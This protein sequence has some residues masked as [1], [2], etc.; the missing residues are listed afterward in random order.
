MPNLPTSL[1]TAA[2]IRSLEQVAI[3]EQGVP[4]LALMER[5]GEAAF[6]HLLGRWPDAGQIAVFCGGGNNAGD[7]YVVARLALQAGLAVAVY[8]VVEPESLQNDALLTYQ[9]YENIGGKVERFLASQPI[10]ADV[11]VDALLGTGLNKPVSGL[12]AQAV[13]AINASRLAV[14]AVDMP[15]G[16]NADTG[17]VMGC[18]V[19]ADCTVT[20]I[21]LKQG[22][23]TGRAADYAGEIAYDSLGVPDAVFARVPVTTCRVE[24][25]RLAAR[26]RY[27]HKGYYGHVLVIGGD[28]GYSGAVR[29]A[30][31]AAL[32]IGAGLVSVATRPEH[33]QWL[34]IGR[35]ELMCYG[36]GS[37]ADLANLL[38]K[39]SVVVVGPGL[40]RTAWGKELFIGLIN[41]IHAADAG[42]YLVIDADALYFLSH[43]RIKNPN[44]ILT[45]HTGEA[46]RLLHVATATIESD[47]FESASDIQRRYDGITVLKGS[48]TVVAAKDEL[49]VS[50]T[51]NPGMASGGMGDVLSGVIGGLLAQGLPPK[52]AAQQGVYLHGL[53]GDKAADYYGERGL[54]ASDLLPYLSQV[55]A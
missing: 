32:R 7:G 23:F 34:N 1:Y 12:M 9:A 54:L 21:G 50:N 41:A 35:P 27:S 48:G 11:V 19:V 29:L 15:S 52:H 28:Y 14:L 49:A 18:A 39:A 8:A 5:A 40:G 30:G 2:Q 22:L 36:I 6:R 45:P 43:A 38:I 17:V 46:A 3:Q 4:G 24:K 25:L 55:V 10:V 37:S 44:W 33:A 20:F 26:P 47:R 13:E 51:G 31:E 16:L 42:K 53:A